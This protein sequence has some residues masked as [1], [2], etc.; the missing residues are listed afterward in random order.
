MHLVRISILMHSFDGRCRDSCG[1]QGVVEPYGAVVVTVIMQQQKEWP[2]DA[3]MC[4]DKFLVQT[5]AVGVG[6]SQQP[7]DLAALF[8]KESGAR[9]T[10]TKLKVRADFFDPGLNSTRQPPLNDL[11]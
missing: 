6:A 8:S 11:R 1:E 3:A 4:K 2:S 9:I 7:D 5:V 10:E